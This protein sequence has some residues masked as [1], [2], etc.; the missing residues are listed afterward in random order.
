M[1]VRPWAPQAVFHQPSDR[2]FPSEESPERPTPEELFVS[3]AVKKRVDL[4]EGNGTSDHIH[5]VLS[6]PP[7]YSIAMLR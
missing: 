6:L 2:T 5:M 1:V 3:C 7:E 4:V